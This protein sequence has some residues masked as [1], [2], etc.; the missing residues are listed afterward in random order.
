MRT[1]S[2]TIS[3]SDVKSIVFFKVDQITTDLI[4]CEVIV[5]TADGQQSFLINE[6][7]PE[8]DSL[9]NAFEMLPGF[10]RQWREKVVLP[11][12]AENRTVAYSQY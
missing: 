11:P 2:P 3:L 4:C 8:F 5:K 12:F 7:M 9:I 1:A 10:D 6:E